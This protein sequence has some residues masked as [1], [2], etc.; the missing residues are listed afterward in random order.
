MRPVGRRVA[1]VVKRQRIGV[2]DTSI[3]CRGYCGFVHAPL[4]RLRFVH[5]DLIGGMVSEL[6]AFVMA[7]SLP[8]RWY[9]VP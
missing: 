1:R 2:G 4:S 6:I 3:R 7:Q 8:G 9:A 5:G